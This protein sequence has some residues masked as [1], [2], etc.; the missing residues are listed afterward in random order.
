MS[1]SLT[2]AIKTLALHTGYV[3]CGITSAAPFDEFANALKDRVSRYPSCAPLY[4]DLSG[5]SNPRL[6][7]P[8]AQ[9]IVVCIRWFGKYYV[10]GTLP[11]AIARTYLFD[12]RQKLCPDN[13]MPRLMKAG[14]RSLG[15]KV[16]RGGVPDRWAAVRAGVGQFGRNAFVYVKP[17][18]SWINIEAFVVD[19]PLDYDNPALDSPCPEGCFACIKSCPTGAL[20]SA[21][22]MRYDQCI[23]YLTYDIP[24]P[25]KPSLAARMGRWVYG[26]DECQLSCPLNKDAWRDMVR[27]EWL[28]PF[29]PYLDPQRLAISDDKTL[30]E[31]VYPLFWYIGKDNIARWRRNA[32]RAIENTT[33]PSSKDSMTAGDIGV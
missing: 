6:H 20:E 18:G 12:R 33:P 8:W 16:A 24:E 5:R 29:L 23:A 7:R 10:D 25:I 4:Q 17:Y 11:E 19:A 1:D 26:C 3:A 2:N 13:D 32:Q 30:L 22:R 27:A 14:L 15:L 28:E 9:S 21:Y 31:N